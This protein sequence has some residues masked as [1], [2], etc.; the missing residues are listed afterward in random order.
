MNHQTNNG[1]ILNRINPEPD[2]TTPVQ[3]GILTTTMAAQGDT[4]ANCSATD[5]VDIKH[6]YVEFETPQEVGVFSDDKTGST[7]QALGEGVI[8][9]ISDQGSIMNW[10]VLLLRLLSYDVIDRTFGIKLM[11]KVIMSYSIR[12]LNCL[13]NWWSHYNCNG[14][15]IFLIEWLSCE[16]VWLAWLQLPYRAVVLSLMYWLVTVFS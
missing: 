7:L 4:G 6:N 1:M 5:T 14:Q 11:S 12:L 3:K 15:A 2:K 10:T 9:I 13:L 8:K 16:V